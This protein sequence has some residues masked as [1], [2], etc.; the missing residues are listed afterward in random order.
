VGRGWHSAPGLPHAEAIA[1]AQA[2]SA[3][4]GATLYV[5]LEPCAHHGRT[6]PCTDAILQSGVRRVVASIQDP[7]PLVDGRGFARLRQAGIEVE[8]GPAAAAARRLNDGFLH[9]HEHGRPLVT[10]KAAASLDGMIA[11][12]GGAARWITGECA[13]RFAHRLRLRH[14][15]VLVG[16]ETVRRDDPRLTVRLTGVHARRWRCVLAPSLALE[17]EA[18][19]FHCGPDEWPPRI[20]AAGEAPAE[21]AARLSPL[22]E[23]VRVPQREGW[24]DLAAVLA[25]LARVGVQSVL[26]EGGAATHAAFLEAGLADRLALFVAPRL[27]GARGGVPLLDRPVAA[28]PGSGWQVEEPCQLALGGDLALLGRIAAA[29]GGR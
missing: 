4:R 7:N 27:L 21:R 5:N 8:V 11:A 12:A 29:A 13:R 22:A 16:A 15:A 28:L 18:A 1:L 6:P 3:A 20:Y 10:L 17:P 19:L 26:V 9:Y 2:G 24:L 14:D 23:I 25:D